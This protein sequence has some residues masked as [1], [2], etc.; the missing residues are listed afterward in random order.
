MCTPMT[1]PDQPKSK[2]VNTATRRFLAILL[3][4]LLGVFGLFFF[5]PREPVYDEQPI[6]Y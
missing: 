2:I 4:S 1:E 6:S 5:S 3:V